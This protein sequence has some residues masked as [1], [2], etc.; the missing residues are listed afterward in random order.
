MKD[1]MEKNF[2]ISIR[3]E[4][5]TVYANVFEY[6]HSPAVYHVFF[7][8]HVVPIQLKLYERNEE[9]VADD[10]DHANPE[11]VRKVVVAIKNNPNRI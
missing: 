10:A 7:I 5:R 1:G 2:M 9:I 6:R 4:G 11:L 3:F 8:D